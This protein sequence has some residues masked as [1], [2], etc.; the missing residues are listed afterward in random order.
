MMAMMPGVCP[1]IL[2][3]VGTREVGPGGFFCLE[4]RCPLFVLFILLL[5]T[6]QRRHKA[7]ASGADATVIHPFARSDCGTPGFARIHSSRIRGRK[8]PVQPTKTSYAYQLVSASSHGPGIK[9]NRKLILFLTSTRK[10]RMLVR[11]A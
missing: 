8:T 5:R 7:N 6:P 3:L 9:G 11:V 4:E 1:I 2:D 10:Q